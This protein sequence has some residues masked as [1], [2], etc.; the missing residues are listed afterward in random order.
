MF[1]KNMITN[2]AQMEAYNN[3]LKLCQIGRGTDGIENAAIDMLL[4]TPEADYIG[5]WCLGDGTLEVSTEIYQIDFAIQNVGIDP[6]AVAEAI[7]IARGI[8]PDFW[9]GHENGYIHISEGSRRSREGYTLGY[10]F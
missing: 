1:S 2:A 5:F 3:L 7:C 9:G 6:H 8:E 10:C 4:V